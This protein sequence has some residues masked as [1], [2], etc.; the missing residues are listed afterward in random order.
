MD[1]LKYNIYPFISAISGQ[2]FYSRHLRPVPLTLLRLIWCLLVPPLLVTCSYARFM[3]S[4]ISDYTYYCILFRQLIQRLQF[5]V[6]NFVQ[7]VQISNSNVN[8][9]LIGPLIGEHNS[10]T[11][12]GSCRIINSYRKKNW[13]KMD[14][15]CILY[16]GARVYVTVMEVCNSFKLSYYSIWNIFV[17]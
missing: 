13:V 17:L 8:A 14:Y 12:V 1:N 5:F 11:T 9:C 6:Q 3:F 7:N 15:I 4:Q 2:H 16:M 10:V